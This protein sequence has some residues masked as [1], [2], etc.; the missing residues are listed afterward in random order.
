MKKALVL[1]ALVGIG[2]YATTALSASGPTPVEK[3]LQKDVATLKKQVKTL[4]SQ[5]KTLSND[6]GDAVSTLA[7]LGVCQAELTT[8]ALQSTWQ[9]V[10]QLS[11]ATQAGKTYF[12]PQTPI[13]VNVNGRDWC[14]L[15]N[16]T[17]SQVLP[18]T[19]AQYQALL[20]PFRGSASNSLGRAAQRVLGLKTR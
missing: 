17:R 11:A 10:D 2:V 13:A 20:A 19:I 8:D 3:A 18:P 9:I 14:S 1:C 4:Q 15:A 7:I 12:G 5:V 6:T 16:V